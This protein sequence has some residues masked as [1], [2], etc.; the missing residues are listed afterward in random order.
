ML[1]SAPKPAQLQPP[2]LQHFRE[3]R[4]QQKRQFLLARHRH[5]VERAQVFVDMAGVAHDQMASPAR[6][7]I[8]FELLRVIMARIEIGKA[9]ET[10][11][12]G[13]TG[14]AR[15]SEEARGQPSH[16]QGFFHLRAT[17]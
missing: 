12:R 8:S 5:R 2:P 7:Q 1:G 14:A 11:I 3:T 16:H 15:G 9:G 13:E 10:N 17:Q 4:R 6:A